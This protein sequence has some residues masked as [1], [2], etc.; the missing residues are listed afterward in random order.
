M[1]ERPSNP[2]EIKGY[3]VIVN[4]AKEQAIKARVQVEQIRHDPGACRCANCT[5]YWVNTFNDYLAL[6]LI[7]PDTWETNEDVWGQNTYFVV[8]TRRGM[9][10]YSNR[11]D[12]EKPK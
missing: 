7:D 2:I 6:A 9:I 11:E 10:I 8:P 3:E 4:Y 1:K 5:K 12:A